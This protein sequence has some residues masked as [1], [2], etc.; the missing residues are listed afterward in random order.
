[1]NR[2]FAAI[3]A[4]LAVVAASPAQAQQPVK[5]GLIMPYSGQFADAA[6]QMDK[7]IKLYTKEHGDTVAGRKLEIIRRDTG[8]VAPDVAK[9][10]AQE[11]VVR[12]REI[13]RA[14]V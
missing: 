4:A 3:F 10:H 7:A 9:R 8:G 6:A 2:H 14:H 13:G 12:D 5:I 1:M 11:L